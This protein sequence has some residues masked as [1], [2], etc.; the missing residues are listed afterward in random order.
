MLLALFVPSALAADWW[1]I[2]SER[3]AA[4]E[5]AVRTT[6]AG[7]VATVADGTARFDA[8]GLV[9]VALAA[10]ALRRHINIKGG[11][12]IYI[13]LLGLVG[14]RPAGA[15]CESAHG[16]E[17]V[18]V[19][20]IVPDEGDYAWSIVGED[21]SMSC[22]ATIPGEGFFDCDVGSYG[23]A[24]PIAAEGGGWTF[25]TTLTTSGDDAV[26]H[27]M[28]TSGETTL[29][30]T[31]FAPDWRPVTDEGQC[32]EFTHASQEFDL[33]EEADTGRGSRSRSG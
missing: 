3:L 19:A 12:V 29:L 23:F 30:D 1:S 4:S 21:D 15:G 5:R 7:F 13:T 14:C 8:S 11:L 10:A 18:S 16:P 28:L 2:A 25:G 24:V 6:D 9:G 26:V 17:G 33:R 31:D 32:A 22:V 20:F 27:V